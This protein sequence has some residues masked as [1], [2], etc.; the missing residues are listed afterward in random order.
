MF[1]NGG[2]AM[3]KLGLRMTSK[4]VKKLVTRQQASLNRCHGVGAV[5]Y[6]IVEMDQRIPSN[7]FFEDGRKFRVRFRLYGA[8]CLVIV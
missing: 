7:E 8:R 4:R 1:R 2:G 6:A 3:D 5:G